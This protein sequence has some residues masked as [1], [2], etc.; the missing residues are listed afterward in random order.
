MSFKG[1][2]SYYLR[3][4]LKVDL[5]IYTHPLYSLETFWFK[6]TCLHEYGKICF[7]DV[8]IIDFLQGK[9]LKPEN[10]FQLSRDHALSDGGPAL[11]LCGV[12]E[13]LRGVVQFTWVL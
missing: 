8:F 7:P 13:R 6:K 9:I 3:F 12:A 11:Y 5:Q 1:L 2:H 4:E 10:V